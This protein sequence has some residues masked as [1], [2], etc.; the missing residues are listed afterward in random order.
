MRHNSRDRQRVPGDLTF[1]L[2]PKRPD[3]MSD[4][5]YCNSDCFSAVMCEEY[6]SE[7]QLACFYSTFTKSYSISLFRMHIS[8]YQTPTDSD[9]LWLS[10]RLTDSVSRYICVSTRLVSTPAPTTPNKAR[11][12]GQAYLHLARHTVAR[13]LPGPGSKACRADKSS[14]QRHSTSLIRHLCFHPAVS[15]I[16]WL[17]RYARQLMT[18]GQP[19]AGPAVDMRT[20]R[21]T[22]C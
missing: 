10:Q 15:E 3:K 1:S 14:A 21:D 18:S 7:S 9:P 4:G 8:Y 6:S 19:A 16:S 5:Q 17:A 20:F 11:N 12:G 22:P 2:R 13:L